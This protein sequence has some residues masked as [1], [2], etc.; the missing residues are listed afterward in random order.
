[1]ETLK[2]VRQKNKLTQNE[3]CSLLGCSLSYYVKL[4]QGK[5]KPGREF[6]K[7]FSDCFPFEDIRGLL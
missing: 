3:M 4:E 5:L 6:I 2:Q 7:R 1:M